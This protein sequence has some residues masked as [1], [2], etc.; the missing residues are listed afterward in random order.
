RIWC[1]VLGVERVGRHDNFFELGGHS[2]LC[3][4]LVAR[5]QAAM[6]SALSI[7]DVFQHP[8][9]HDIAALIAGSRAVG[10]SDQALSDIES[11]MDSMETA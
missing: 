9:L 11:L 3:A 8:L 1:E 2:L 7:Q 10:A 6:P 4:Q 5:V